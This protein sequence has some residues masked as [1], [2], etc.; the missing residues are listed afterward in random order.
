MKTGL[1]CLSDSHQQPPLTSPLEVCPRLKANHQGRDQRG[2]TPPSPTTPS[3][4]SVFIHSFFQHSS[5]EQTRGG[6]LSCHLPAR[7]PGRRSSMFPPAEWTQEMCPKQLASMSWKLR[8]PRAVEGG[9]SANCQ[10]TGA[11]LGVSSL[12]TGAQKTAA[13]QTWLGAPLCFQGNKSLPPDT[14][15]SR[16]GAWAR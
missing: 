6:V 13:T 5:L 2:H 4:L 1:F 9:A 8:T 11:E 7:P 15:S 12:G 14:P 16:R 10:R 3:E